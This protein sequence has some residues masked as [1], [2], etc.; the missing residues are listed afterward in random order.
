MADISDV[1]Q[2][3]LA[4]AVAAVYPNGTTQPSIAAT[5]IKLYEGW[6]NPQQ[7]DVDLAAGICHV[8]IFTRQEEKNTT[9]YTGEWKP[10][11]IN[12]PTLTLTVNGQTVTVGGVMPSPFI[13]HN[14]T[15][16]VNGLPYVYAALSGDTLNS[17]A[18]AL[19]ALIPG[20]SASGAAITMSSTAIINAAR[21]GMTGTAIR[22]IRQQERRFQIS[23]WAD[24]PTHR[25]QIASAIDVALADLRFVSLPDGTL[26]R[27]IYHGSPV[28]DS[29]QNEQIYR[30]D[31]IYAVDYSTT[32]AETETQIT[33][34]QLNIA[35]QPHG[36][37]I[38]NASATIY[39]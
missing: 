16:M 30:R 37:T 27:L 9:R 18:A 5:P 25:S 1:S 6:P 39:S 26:G 29:L 3:L 35:S 36:A 8:S 13:A 15:I 7:L 4:L 17:I 14:L 28:N 21:V 12:T 10:V 23:I 22:N 31:L 34:T 11:S 20:A 2:A 33:N 19:S 38:Y 24:T 32:Q